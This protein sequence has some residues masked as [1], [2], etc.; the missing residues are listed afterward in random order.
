MKDSDYNYWHNLVS[1]ERPDEL[2]SGCE[3]QGSE[4]WKP[5]TNDPA[6]W[7]YMLRRWPKDQ[8]AHYEDLTAIP[9]DCA[10]DALNSSTRERLLALKFNECDAVNRGE[11]EW[12]HCSGE[13]GNQTLGEFISSWIIDTSIATYRLRPA[14]KMR[15]MTVKE[16]LAIT[17]PNGLVFRNKRN[18]SIVFTCWTNKHTPESHEH[19]RIESLNY[20]GTGGEWQAF[21]VEA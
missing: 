13:L 20:D 8:R 14:P 5:E 1:T 17:S 16:C 9:K 7:G 11:S 21:E 15:A 4:G 3:F 6:V 19:A 18:A 2:P 10:L 12:S